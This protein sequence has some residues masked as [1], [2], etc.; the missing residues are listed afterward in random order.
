MTPTPE[1]VKP[2]RPYDARRRR[3]RA[4]QAR[5]AVVDAA[6]AR[7]LAD[8]Y[9]ATTV[10]SVA[11]DAGLSVETVYKAF[12]SKAGLVRAVFEQDLAGEDAV[13]TGERADRV[14]REER[15]GEKRLRAFGGFLAEVTQ[16][17][18]PIA[19]LVRDAAATSPDMHELW[20]ELQAARLARMAM[21]AR[22]LADDGLLRPGVTADEA[23]DV[24]WACSGP[25]LFDLLV[26]RRGWT[27]ERFGA[28]IGDAYVAA[29][30]P[31]RP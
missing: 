11:A 15:D 30:L 20:E 21:H 28:W 8:G 31:R 14:S 2:R 23:R 13:T 10:A 6:R 16:R 29:L 18:G 27:P 17:A 19:L 9:A 1:P 26:R 25:E 24:L 7:F 5:R 4:A 12:G 22:R 3:E